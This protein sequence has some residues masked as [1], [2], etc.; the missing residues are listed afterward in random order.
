MKSL[1]TST[2]YKDEMSS[3]DVALDDWHIMIEHCT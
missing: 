2:Q 1:K 3:P